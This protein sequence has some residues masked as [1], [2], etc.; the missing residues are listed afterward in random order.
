MVRPEGLCQWLHCARSR[1]VAGSI[2]D[3]VTDIIPVHDFSLFYLEDSHSTDVYKSVNVY[4][5]TR[6]HF[7]KDRNANSQPPFPDDSEVTQLHSVTSHKTWT[8]NPQISLPLQ[9]AHPKR[10][11]LS[12]ASQRLRPFGN[13]ICVLEIHY[14][15]WQFASF[16]TRAVSCDG[17]Q[18]GVHSYSKRP[19]GQGPAVYFDVV[20][21]TS[22]VH[23]RHFYITA[24]SVQWQAHS[25]F[26]SEF[27]T[28]CNLLLPLSIDSTLFFP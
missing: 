22:G 19:V 3:G 28:Q 18:C 11:A 2:P 26:Q 6:R 12:T 1:K 17:R 27:L 24:L 8:F 16:F 25:H 13:Q 23:T 7:L 5:T 9:L 10:T 15:I 21:W 20:Q 14:F 4:Q